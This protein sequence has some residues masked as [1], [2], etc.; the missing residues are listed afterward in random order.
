MTTNVSTRQQEIE[1][2]LKEHEK[3]MLQIEMNAVAAAD[4]IE[5]SIAYL[6]AMVEKMMDQIVRNKNENA[7]HR[8][9]RL[10]KIKF[11]RFIREDI[12][13][14]LYKVEV[15]FTIYESP[16][17]LKLRYAIL[18]LEGDVLQWHRTY[19]KTKGMSIDELTW[20]EFV[21][22]ISE[23]FATSIED[24]ME[25][26]KALYQTGSFE[27]YFNSFDAWLSKV[28]FC[29]EYA[30][31]IF[32]GGLKP[33]LKYPLKMFRPKTLLDAYS[34]ARMQDNANATLNNNQ[35]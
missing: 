30:I 10:C 19:M 3:M 12:K 26:M 17:Q 1:K 25:E 18:H 35:G 13:G 5:R 15:F 20:K 22:S 2:N 8:L 33:E 31:S 27:D 34:L 9:T 23:K 16:E 29:E 32:L 24:A 7:N 14:W 21:M 11:P 4:R 6:K 28:T